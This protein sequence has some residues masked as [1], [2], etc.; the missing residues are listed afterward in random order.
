M[1]AIYG[2]SR[3]EPDESE[4]DVALA[5]GDSLLIIAHRSGVLNSYSD[6]ANITE[7]SMGT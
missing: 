7:L 3:D 2:I 5:K 4:D 1:P 6:G